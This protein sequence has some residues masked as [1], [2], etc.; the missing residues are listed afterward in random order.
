MYQ[1]FNLTLL[2]ILKEIMKKKI[3]IKFKCDKCGKEQKPDKKQSNAN[4]EVYP[5]IPC[6]CGGNF[7]PDVEKK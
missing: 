6:E 4:W 5:N 2:S 7:I 1:R 3:E